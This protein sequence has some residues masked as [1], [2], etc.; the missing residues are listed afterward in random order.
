MCALEN[1]VWKL[2]GGK[3]GICKIIE[4][5]LWLNTFWKAGR[6]FQVIRIVLKN[7]FTISDGC[8]NC[9]KEVRNFCLACIGIDIVGIGK[10]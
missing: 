6:P 10:T 2:Q 8:N 9:M 3:D 7:I 5:S 4:R 1:M